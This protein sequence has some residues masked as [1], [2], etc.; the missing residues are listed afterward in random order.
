MTSIIRNFILTK[1]FS[2]SIN[3]SKFIT[4]TYVLF[5][6]FIAL[7]IGLELRENIKTAI[8]HRDT[9]SLSPR[10][11]EEEEKMNGR[12][13][14]EGWRRKGES[15]RL[16]APFEGQ[17]AF[18]PRVIRAIF[19]SRSAKTI[20]RRGGGGLN[21][22]KKSGRPCVES[23]EGVATPPRSGNRPTCLP[24]RASDSRCIAFVAS[25]LYHD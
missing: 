2:S 6:S 21:E 4:A 13:T 8:V 17:N 24:L 16:K 1:P 7:R 15:R 22:R 11:Q 3:R 18:V 25:Q 10:K 5:D 12:W 23:R 9:S 20:Q 19:R 14:L